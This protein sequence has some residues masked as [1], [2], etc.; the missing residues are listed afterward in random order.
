[1]PPVVA[2][3]LIAAAGTV[4]GTTIGG[5]IQSNAAKKAGNL[6]ADAASQALQFQRE[7]SRLDRANFDATQQANYA[8]YAAQQQRQAPYQQIGASAAGT[9]Q[10]RLGLPQ[11]SLPALPP[12]PSLQSVSALPGAGSAS[13]GSVAG[14]GGAVL[15]R[16]PDGTTKQVPQGQVAYYTQ[17]GATKVGG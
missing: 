13:L 12:P 16:A 9:L 14:T 10:Q 8:Q 1:M 4:A 6:Q 15:M 3:S 17:K 11:A 2:A 5:K 7:Q